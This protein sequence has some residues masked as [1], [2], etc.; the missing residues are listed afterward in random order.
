MAKTWAA[1]DGRTHVVPQD[2]VTLASPVLC[3]RLILDAEAAFRGVTVDD[4]VRAA[5]GR[6][7]GPPGSGLTDGSIGPA[8]GPGPDPGAGRAPAGSRALVRMLG[9]GAGTVTTVGRS[10]VLL[11]LLAWAVHRWLGWLEFGVVAAVGAFLLAAAL[12]LVLLPAAGASA[13]SG[14]TPTG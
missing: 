10:V 4:V 12:V 11:T 5:H 7:P 6:R 13:G 14:S 8:P 9:A 2:V 3:H 1:A